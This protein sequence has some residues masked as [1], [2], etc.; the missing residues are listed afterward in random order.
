MRRALP[1][2]LAMLVACTGPTAAPPADPTSSPVTTS[3]VPASSSTVSPHPVSLAAMIDARFDGRD[4][5][6]VRTVNRTSNTVVSD[7]RY[8]GGGLTLSGRL[9]VPT[10]QGPFPVV[11]LNHGYIDPAVYTS[12]RG[13]E[14]SQQVLVDAGFAALHIDYR[15]H[16]ASDRDPRSDLELRLGYVEDAINAVRAI[17]RSNLPFLDRERIAMLGR[18]MG[19]GVTLGAIA[20]V[21]DLVDA[22]VI[23]S[24]V[25]SRMEE[26]FARFLR[27]RPELASAIIA[28]YG[29]P[30][31][32]PA[33]WR[34]VSP[35][36]YLDR[37]T[38]PVLVQHGTADETCPVRWSDDTVRALRAADVEVTYHRYPGEGH[39]F[40]SSAF[41]L[42][43][44][45]TVAFLRAHLS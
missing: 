1:L 6:I 18:S 38:T 37:V 43:S 5:R 44:R 10:G 17:E 41:D 14:R 36:T 11:V 13:F 4:L 21:P 33:F 25:S 30:T 24:S 28:A 22:A 19:G 23:V 9:F 35:R 15:N 16:A 12:G 29:S 27:D 2:L 42:A 39:D 40:G 31:Q 20:V 7:V 26:N 8:E 32:R 34:G 45:R 3:P